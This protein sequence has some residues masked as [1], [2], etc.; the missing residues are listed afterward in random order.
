MI[1]FR[2][3]TIPHPASQNFGN[4]RADT[5]LTVKRPPPHT[6]DSNHLHNHGNRARKSWRSN[7]PII[8][9]GWR[10]HTGGSRSIPTLHPCPPRWRGCGLL[11]NTTTINL[12]KWSTMTTVAKAAGDKEWGKLEKI[13]AWQLT[14]VRNK[15]RG[16]R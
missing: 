12:R 8:L 11:T 10:R 6:C 3:Q 5:T 2:A 9:P 15:K 13:P 16:D 7:V 1:L 14:K 4:V